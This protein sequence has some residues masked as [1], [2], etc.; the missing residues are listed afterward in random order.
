MRE[1]AQISDA[2]VGVRADSCDPNVW[3]GIHHFCVRGVPYGGGRFKVNLIY[4][5]MEGLDVI[6]GMDWLASN[7]VVIDC[8]Q[9][10]VVFP[11]VE[12][13][14]LIY[15]TRQRRRLKIELLAL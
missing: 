6:L 13:L 11:N 2:I 1:E 3:R 10:I 12:G 9:H 14:E 4:L 15:R 8:E 5:P 7:H